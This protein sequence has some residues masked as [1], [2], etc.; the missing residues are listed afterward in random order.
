M[1]VNIG[2]SQQAAA[3][4][5][6]PLPIM[7][8][9][10]QLLHI[11]HTSEA[12]AAFIYDTDICI[13]HTVYTA[14]HL[15]SHSDIWSYKSFVRPYVKLDPPWHTTYKSHVSHGQVGCLIPQP[16]QCTSVPAMPL[17]GMLFQPVWGH[18]LLPSQGITEPTTS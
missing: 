2:Y 10:T 17:G 8:V 11:G 14:P 4:H 13:G 7:C 6:G 3:R 1:L 18:A 15:L 5:P 9:S 16:A 12:I